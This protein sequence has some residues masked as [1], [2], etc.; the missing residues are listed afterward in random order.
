MFKFFFLLPL[1]FL[2]F[3]D[4]PDDHANAIAIDYLQDEGIVGG[5]PDGSFKPDNTIN[6]AEFTKIIVESWFSIENESQDP[7]DLGFTDLEG[8]WYVPYVRIAYEE[9]LIDGYPDGSFRPEAEINFVEAA[10]IISNASGATLVETEIWYLPYLYFLEEQSA[11]PLTVASLDAQLT[12][13][14]MAEM[15]LR[16]RE[17]IT[18]FPSAS[19][20]DLE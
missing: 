5:Y 8:S 15:I 14:E 11:I 19:V 20:A 9:G 2:S 13:G 18:E 10:K 6:R 3:F 16:L 4:V 1:S 7:Q 17:G 12:R